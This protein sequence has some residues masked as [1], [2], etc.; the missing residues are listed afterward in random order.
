MHI[1]GP[2]VQVTFETKKLRYPFEVRGPPPCTL[3]RKVLLLLGWVRRWIGRTLVEVQV[4]RKAARSAGGLFLS[5]LI[6]PD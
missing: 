6:L 3:V 2:T 1:N 4:T 5:V